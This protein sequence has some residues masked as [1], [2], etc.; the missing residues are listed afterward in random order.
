MLSKLLRIFSVILI[1][2]FILSACA[3][4]T[5]QAEKPPLRVGWSLWPGWYPMLIAQEKG[6]FEKHGVVV[7]IVFY[8]TYKDTMPALG[9]GLLDGGALALGDVL[10]DDVSEDNHIVLVTDG[11]NGADQ[12][13]AAPGITSPK[14]LRGKRIGVQAGTYGE[15]LVQKM[16]DANGLTRSDITLVEVPVEAIP[17]A[18]P[19]TIDA[20]HTYEPYAGQAREKGAN[21]IFT[22]ADTPGLLLDVFAFRSSVLDE[23]P[24]DVK[25]FIAAW[26]EAVQFW[27]D[28]PV[29]GNEIIARALGLQVTDISLEGI[30]LY[31]LADNKAAFQKGTETTS[32]YYPARTE[33]QFLSDK[34][35][36]SYPI[37]ID[38]H[39]LNPSFLP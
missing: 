7:E 15:I 32:I 20:G 4:T 34:G 9:S 8:E 22:S 38:E 6:L 37:Q 3:P 10:L 24:E 17:D 18:I 13:V 30:K 28:N 35:I 19:G 31:G 16:L 25:A 12:V 1:T 29:E 14:D 11:S 36:I 5:S 27:Q 33:L 23:R 39:F 26:L 21:P 2:A